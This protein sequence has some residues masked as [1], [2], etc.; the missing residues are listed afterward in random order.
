MNGWLD[1]SVV[2]YIL[3]NMEGE[4]Y[5]FWENHKHTSS[6]HLVFYFMNINHF[7]FKLTMSMSVIILNIILS[8]SQL[9]SGS[10]ITFDSS[11]SCRAFTMRALWCLRKHFHFKIYFVHELSWTLAFKKQNNNNSKWRAHMYRSKTTTLSM[12]TCMCLWMEGNVLR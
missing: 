5:I 8:Y 11:I 2:L 10:V 9:N 1:W 4:L 3:F 7:A 6:W 12:F